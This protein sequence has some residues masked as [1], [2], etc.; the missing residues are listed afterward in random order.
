MR[1]GSVVLCGAVLVGGHQ[2]TGARMWGLVALRGGVPEAR[3]GLR[4]QARRVM[5]PLTGCL[6]GFSL[7][8]G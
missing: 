2:G 7:G 1:Q 5:G 4:A 3:V 6:A 8:P